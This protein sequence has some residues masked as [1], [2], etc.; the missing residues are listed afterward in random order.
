MYI[1]N[2][3]ISSVACSSEVANSER[4]CPVTMHRID[5]R[6][7]TGTGTAEPLVPQP[8]SRS[9]CTPHNK[10]TNWSSGRGR[11]KGEQLY[12]TA[13]RILISDLDCCPLMRL[14]HTTFCLRSLTIAGQMSLCC[15][16]ERVGTHHRMTCCPSKFY[17]S[18]ADNIPLS[19][20]MVTQTCL[21]TFP[22]N[23]WGQNYP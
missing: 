11:E 1:S 3:W 20:S 7:V 9:L 15:R 23:S 16:E 14:S 5:A 2:D 17:F 19:A 10:T 21:E 13:N 18:G 12:I 4:K 22:N 6:L 8:S